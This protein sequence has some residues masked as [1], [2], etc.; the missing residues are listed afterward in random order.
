[1]SMFS[2]LLQQ[3]VSFAVLYKII[4]VLH[5]KIASFRFFSKYSTDK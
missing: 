5:C 1:M 2:A 4:V 3:Q